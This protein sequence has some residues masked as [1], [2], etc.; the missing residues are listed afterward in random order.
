MSIYDFL[1]L[2]IEDDTKVAVYDM[3]H[4]VEVFLGEAKD[5]MDCGFEEYEV[6][7]FDLDPFDPRGVLM[8]LNIECDEV[9]EEDE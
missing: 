1:Q 6:L 5:A 2:L 9:E 4:D 3:A 8:V 7:S